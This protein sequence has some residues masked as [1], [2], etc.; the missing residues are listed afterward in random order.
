M[1]YQWGTSS[2]DK[3]YQEIGRISDLYD[4]I[5]DPYEKE[6]FRQTQRRKLPDLLELLSKELK[7]TP[8]ISTLE[9]KLRIPVLAPGIYD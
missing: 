9:E 7:S 5:N 6:I 3:A 2:E 4:K 1:V 8:L